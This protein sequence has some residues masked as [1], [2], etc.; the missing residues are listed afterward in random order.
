MSILVI[1]AAQG[2]AAQGF[3]APQGFFTAQGFLAAHGFMRALRGAHGLARQ[4]E[5]I[6]I[7]PTERVRT[8]EAISVLTN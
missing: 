6:A 4:G 1:P 8:P 3:I 2:L 5:A 7:P